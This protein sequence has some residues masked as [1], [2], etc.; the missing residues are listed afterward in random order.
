MGFK[1]RKAWALAF[2]PAF[3]LAANTAFAAG[4]TVALRTDNGADGYYYGLSGGGSDRY[5]NQYL[6]SSFDPGSIICGARWQ[7]LNQGSIPPPGIGGGDLRRDDA[8]NPGYPDLVDGTG[9]IQT[10]DVASQGTCAGA[11][12]RIFTFT[13]NV[14]GPDVD[15]IH[16]ISAIEPIRGTAGI[17]FCGTRLDTTGVYQGFAKYYSGGVFGAIPWNH[18]IE[19]IVFTSKAMDLNIRASGSARF[20]GDRGIPA[21]FTTRANA[22]ATA[23]DDNIT[24]SISIDNGTGGS[25]G[26]NLRICADQSVIDPKKGLKEITGFFKPVGG[27]AGIMN[28]LTLASGRTILKLE[29]SAG[30]VKAQAAA[31]VNKRVLNLPLRVLVD[32]PGLDTDLCALDGGADIDDEVQNLGL[33]RRPGSADDN[34]I[35]AYFVV[36]NP[37]QVGDSLNVR[38]KA[39]DMPKVSYNVTGFEVVGGEF[40]GSG[41]PGLDCLELRNEDAVFSGDADLTVAG[42]LRR[43]GAD[44]G[45]G[46]VPL[47]PPQPGPTF[48]GV[49]FNSVDINIDPTVDPGLVSN[50]YVRGLLLPGESATVTAIGADTAP[51]DT[52]LGDSS[53]TV[54]GQQPGTYVLT[55]YALRALVNGDRSTL[56]GLPTPSGV[57]PDAFVREVGKDIAIDRK[58]GRR[59]Q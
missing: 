10:V 52:I 50:L 41:L 26:R 46:E 27:G 24:L 19:E 39:I 38:F 57:N 21:V 48:V 36:Q 7:E 18:F 40:G 33:R 8:A 11:T 2:A 28:P 12:T 35:E 31:I 5:I 25:I 4:G 15:A 23:T 16:Y 6:A 47:G 29:V 14:A 59:I 32:D 49:V 34:S 22:G 45:V 20:P 37:N 13:P 30:P 3:V 43:F 58:T 56:E 42:L 54:S 9:L 55:N 1:V 17:D 51:G 44:D 53:F